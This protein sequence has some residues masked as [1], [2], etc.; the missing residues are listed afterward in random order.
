MILKD[1][2]IS[3]LIHQE[4]LNDWKNILS[5][6]DQSIIYGYGA[7]GDRFLI[8]QTASNGINICNIIIWYIGI[9]F[10]IFFS[11]LSFGLY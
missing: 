1:L 10:F 4:D 8:N 5:K 7:Q 3:K 9:I 2:L 11:I 6:I